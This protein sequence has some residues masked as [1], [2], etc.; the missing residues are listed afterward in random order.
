M[1]KK[2]LYLAIILATLSNKSFLY[3]LLALIN[4]VETIIIILSLIALK[5]DL[6]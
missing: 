5:L 3:L 4:T 2:T 6:L 1:L